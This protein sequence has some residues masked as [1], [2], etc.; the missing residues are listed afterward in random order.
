M[1]AS[2][3]TFVAGTLGL[4]V[5]E[6]LSLGGAFDH[7]RQPPPSA[8]ERLRA[9]LASRPA[10]GIVHVSHSTHVLC[11]SGLRILTDPWFSDPAFGALAH[12]RAPAC[13]PEDLVELDAVLVTHDHPDHADFA[14]LDRLPDKTNLDLL[15]GSRELETKARR[16]GFPNVR[17][18]APWETHELE[19]V[20]V[21]AV[22]ALHDVPE[23]GFVVSARGAAIYFAGDSAPHPHFTA[24]R[25]RLQPTFAILPVDGTRLRGSTRTTMN[26]RD[27]ARA[28][29]ELGVRAA[30]PS[31]ADARF[32]DPLAEHVLTA[33]ANGGS[34]RFRS[35]M[36]RLIPAVRCETPAPGAF[37][38]V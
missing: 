37:V 9:A 30:M 6:A 33:S 16:R 18:L 17:V 26:A 21:H 22:P 10:F 34:E 28:A 12:A 11:A 24:I 20:V 1:N 8:R 27:A 31:H 35:E 14:A 19:G 7:R 29:A 3:R 5:G 15:V 2:R 25:E 23:I 13:A 36:A 38:A 32:T 4:G